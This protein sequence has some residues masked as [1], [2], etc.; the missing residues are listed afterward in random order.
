[1][2]KIGYWRQY[3]DSEENLPWPM[4]RKLPD[5]VKH[6]VILYLTRGKTHQAWMGFSNCRLCGCRN[7]TTCLTDGSFVWPEGYGHYID[8]H[9]VMVDPDLLAHILTQS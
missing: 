7:G 9:D 8:K 1:M 6:K 4:V 5:E 3:E 2:K